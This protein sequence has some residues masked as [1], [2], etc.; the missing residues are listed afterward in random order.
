MIRSRFAVSA[1]TGAAL[2]LP[3]AATGAP[4][5]DLSQQFSLLGPAKL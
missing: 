4:G 5:A 1:L 2:L 3:L